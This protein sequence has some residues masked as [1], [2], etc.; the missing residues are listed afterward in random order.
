MNQHVPTV[1]RPATYQDVIDAPQ[2]MVAELVEGALHRH[3][4]PSPRPTRASSSLGGELKGFAL[5][6]GAWTL[7]AALGGDGEVRV[8]P[9]DAIA[10][11]L[12]VLWAD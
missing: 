4:R 2:T 5:R 10:F 7:V 6:E 1:R 8:A 3:P 11:P 12:S 9:F